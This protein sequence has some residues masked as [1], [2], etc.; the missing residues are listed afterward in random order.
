[1]GFC[2]C[3]PGRPRLATLPTSPPIT[4]GILMRSSPSSLFLLAFLAP[5]LCAAEVDY[6][7]DIKPIFSARCSSCHGAVRQRGKL[8]LDAAALIRKGGKHGAVVVPGK[9][10]ESLLLDAVRGKDRPRMPP[11][12]EGTGLSDRDIAL[13][14]SWIAQGAR[15]PDEPIPGDPREHWAFR[16]PTRPVVPQGAA[17]NAVA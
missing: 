12:Q 1:M 16:P 10:A 17:A 9:P 8:R 7:R 2:S 11:E 14:E 6:V 4:R 5:S 15:M 13:L 3:P